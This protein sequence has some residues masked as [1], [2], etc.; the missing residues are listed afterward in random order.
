MAVPPSEEKPFVT[1]FS[2]N[3][4]ARVFRCFA[5]PRKVFAEI[6]HK[7]TF[8]W[9]LLL[10][11][12]L[13]LSVQLVLSPRIDM[14]ATIARSMSQAGREIP[15]ER[16]QEAVRG[17]ERFRTFGLIV[18]PLGALAVTFLLGGVYFLALKVVGSEAEYP[19][20][21]STVAHAGFPPSAAQSVLLAVVASTRESFPAQEIPRLLKSN[22]AAFLP[23]D[24][25]KALS[26]LGEVLDIFNVWYWVLLAW[27]LST[28]GKV[29]LRQ[30]A[31]VVAVL[32]GAWTL[33]R[34]VLA[35]VR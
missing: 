31:G 33:V 16:L 21:L 13:T 35:L 17:A 24:A 10:S 25:P 3:A 19:G 2:T 15:E 23:E 6:A 11:A 7:P 20:V 1:E 29:S 5:E 9:V 12:A 18:G 28:V 8:F 32:W 4:L 26:G 34:V 30:S 27:G 14:E 22:L